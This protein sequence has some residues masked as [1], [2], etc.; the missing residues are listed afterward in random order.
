MAS[1]ILQGNEVSVVTE[2]KKA[3][4]RISQYIANDKT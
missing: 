1:G 3:L 2:K 4:K